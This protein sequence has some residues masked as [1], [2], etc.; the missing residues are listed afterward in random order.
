MPGPSGPGFEATEAIGFGWNAVMQ[1]FGGVSVPL[2][3]AAI[4]TAVPN[5]ALSFARAFAMGMF[6]SSLDPIVLAILNIVSFLVTYALSLLI[7]A[8]IMAGVAQFVLKVARGERPEF[9]VVFGGGPFFVPMLGASLLYSFGVGAGAVLC[10]VP[11]LFLAGSWVAYSAFVVDKGMGPIEALSASW[12]ATAPYRVNALVYMLLSI[13]VGFAGVL[14]CGLG[15][16]LVSYPVIMVG[17]AYI[18]LK[19]I[20]EQPRLAT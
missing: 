17:N 14:A 13:V 16:L 2:A 10:L 8:F 9:G 11:G 7:Q 5:F 18:Y 19:L 20:G 6:G 1:N 3:V 4:V 15:A 12:R